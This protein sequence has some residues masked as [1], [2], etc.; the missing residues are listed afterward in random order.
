MHALWS[1]STACY[2]L[3]SRLRPLACDK[4]L[5]IEHETLVIGRLCIPRFGLGRL[6]GVG[7]HALRVLTLIDAPWPALLVL[8]LRP[9]RPPQA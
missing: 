9:G 4:R 6:S 8:G 5:A 1:I 7:V 3:A 2:G